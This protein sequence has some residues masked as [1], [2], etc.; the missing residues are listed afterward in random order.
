MTYFNPQLISTVQRLTESNGTESTISFFQSRYKQLRSLTWFKNW[1]NYLKIGTTLTIC[2]VSTI[3]STY[4]Y[5]LVK[6]TQRE[7]QWVQT[8]GY[9]K[10]S[11][12]HHPK[13]G[14]V[15]VITLPIP[16]CIHRRPSHSIALSWHLTN[17]W[18][19][20]WCSTQ[21]TFK[22][23]MVAPPSFWVTILKI[24]KPVFIRCN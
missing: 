6:L 18:S 24:L 12:A 13:T 7:K 8:I 16:P 3:R 15:I 2:W 23:Q 17:I 4:R 9:K 22:W 1:F 11:E 14:L 21:R 10:Q 19:D 5:H 20:C